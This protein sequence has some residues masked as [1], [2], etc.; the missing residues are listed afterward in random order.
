[1]K[2]I[3]TA[4]F[5]SLIA[6]AGQAQTSETIQFSPGNF[7]TMIEGSITGGAYADY[8]LGAQADQRL[9]AEL[10][11]LSSDGNGTVNFNVLPPGST[12]AAIFIGSISGNVADLILPES[13]DY[14]LR[15]FQMGNDADTGKTTTFGL[16]VSIQ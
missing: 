12:D 16:D 11:A 4:C 10:N 14:T 3:L 8:V 2:A 5:V 15:V 7:G 9:F 1:M 13:G 6:T